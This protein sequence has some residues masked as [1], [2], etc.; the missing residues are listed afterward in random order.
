MHDTELIETPLGK[1]YIENDILH[2][3]FNDGVDVDVDEML[4]SKKVRIALQKGRPMK[5]LVDVCGLFHISKNAKEIAAEEENAKMSIAMAIV[6]SSLGTKII[7]NFFIKLNN[8]HIP[9]KMFNS[10]EKAM[11]WLNTF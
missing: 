8:P 2:I 10:K 9:T 11:E 4:E 3:I 1:H 6:S 5:V 7:S